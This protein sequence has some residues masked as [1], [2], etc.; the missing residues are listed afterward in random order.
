MLTLLRV[1][2]LAII[3]E[4]EVELGPGLNVV[5]GETGAGKSILVGALKLV[6]GSRGSPEMVRSGA[7]RAEVEALFEVGNDPAVRA[8]LEA[9]GAEPGPELVVRRVLPA[10]GRARAYCNGSLATLAQLEELAAGLVDIS[11]QHQHHTL[12]DPATHLGYLDAFARLDGLAGEVRIAHA[13]LMAA[14]RALRE[15]ES[16]LRDRAA[17]EDLLRFQLAEIDKLDPAE[18]EVEQLAEERDRLSHAER[19]RTAAA[20]AEHVIYGADSAVCSKLARVVGDLQ[21]AA[22]HDPALGE[23]AERVAVASTELEE[24]ARD[25]GHYAQRL[26]IEPE[27]LAEIEERLHALKRLVRRHGADLSAVIAFRDQAR[28]ELDQLDQGEARVEA[29]QADQARRLAAAGVQARALSARRHAAAALLGDAMTH[30]LASLGM[31]G[32]RVE[33]AVAPIEGRSEELNVDGARL[34]ATGLDHVEFLIAPNPG[35]EPRPLRKVASGGEL[36]RALLALK[37]VLAGMGGVGLYVFDEVDSGVGGAVAEV[38]GRKLAE[39]ARHHQVLCITHLPQVAI[40]ADR[41]LV[42]A[43]RVEEGRTLSTIRPLSE[44]ERVEEIARML[45]GI[46]QNEETRAAAAAL[47]AGARRREAAAAAR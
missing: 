12:V 20:N 33:V 31:G 27:R 30:E 36:S 47:L 38:I 8:R 43:K 1:R 6:L 15:A 18:D 13:A 28:A 19:L 35:E 40:Y 21:D 10:T 32:A 16:R 39:V 2:N 29:L 24:A 5:T 11:S 17:R 23:L 25:L 46:E 44:A 3:D 7:D 37:R 14:L 45:G 26:G 34:T 42:V 22:R 9:A 41:H 4:L